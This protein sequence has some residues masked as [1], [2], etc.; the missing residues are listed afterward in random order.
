MAAE[1]NVPGPVISIGA[2]V[3]AVQLVVVRNVATGDFEVYRVV[4]ACAN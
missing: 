2:G 1:L 4:L 3:D